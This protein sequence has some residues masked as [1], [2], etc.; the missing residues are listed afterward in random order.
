[1]GAP[2]RH[3]SMTGSYRKVPPMLV[4]TS[5]AASTAPPFGGGGQRPAT[6]LPLNLVAHIVSYLDDVGDIARVTRSCR[7]LYYMT[8]PQLYRRVTLHSYGEMRYVNGRPEGFGSGSP[9]MMGLNGLTT[10]GHAA[11]VEEFRL[12]VSRGGLG[13]PVMMMMTMTMT[14]MMRKKKK[15]ADTDPSNRANG[16]K[17]A[18]KTLQ[19]AEFLTVR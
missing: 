11:L 2:M 8:L 13:E 6:T 7:L 4:Y 17:R 9:F 3:S 10:R 5:P 15:N 19:R 12:W 16:R 18:W 1:M 14:I